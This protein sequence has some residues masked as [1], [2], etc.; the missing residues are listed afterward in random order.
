MMFFWFNVRLLLTVSSCVF[1]AAF[2][3]STAA[4]A[5]FTAAWYERVYAYLCLQR[6]IYSNQHLYG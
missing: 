4:L 6:K 5:E 3:V 2:A 1:T